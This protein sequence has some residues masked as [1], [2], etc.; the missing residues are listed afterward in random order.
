MPRR[1][2]GKIGRRPRND[3]YIDVWEPDHPLARRD[4]YVFEH[5]KIAW[6]NGLLT[7]P[8]LEVH[9]VNHRRDDNRLDNFEIKSGDDHAR[10]HQEE[11]GYVTNQF[12]TFAVKPRDE[13]GSALYGEVRLLR[14]TLPC[15][16]CGGQIPASRRRDAMYCT[17]NCRVKTWKRNHR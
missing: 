17:D 11:R 16:G 1:Y 2:Q 13:R 5:R 9:H 14:D 15:K 4:G 7:D 8:E 6:D 3:G 12:G 10:D